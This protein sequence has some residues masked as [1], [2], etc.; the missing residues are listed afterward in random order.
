MDPGESITPIGEARRALRDILD[1][2]EAQIGQIRT[3]VSHGYAADM[4]CGLFSEG[5]NEG[6]T[7]E[8]DTLRLLGLLGVP[9][10][11]DYLLSRRSSQRRV[12]VLL[13][14]TAEQHG[15]CARARFCHDRRHLERRRLDRPKLGSTSA[16]GFAG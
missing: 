11:L 5:S 7:L 13:V 6:T 9:L 3:F 10:G 2:L 4:F 1:R 12:T 8:P 16:A 14:G 15:K